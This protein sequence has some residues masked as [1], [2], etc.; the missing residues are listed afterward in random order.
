MRPHR[1]P[2]HQGV[3]PDAGEGLQVDILR[4]DILRVDIL[5]VDILRVDIV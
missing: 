3:R 4:V 1:G 2:Q 5:R